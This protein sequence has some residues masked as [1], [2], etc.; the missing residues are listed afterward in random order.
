M[1]ALPQT[2][3]TLPSNKR[4]ARRRRVLLSGKIA[5]SDGAF[6]Y[7]C[8]IRDLSAS[9]ARLGIPGAT[10]LPKEFFLLNLREGTA[11]ACEVIWR[12]AAHTGVRFHDVFALSNATDPGLRFLRRLYVEACLR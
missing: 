10:V 11:Y 12:N 2:E 4:S 9:G 1:T 7:D 5:Y 8:T 3:R 6:S